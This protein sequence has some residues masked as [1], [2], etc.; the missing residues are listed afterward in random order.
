MGTCPALLTRANNNSWHTKNLR[1]YDEG[2]FVADSTQFF[3]EPY[4]T[5]E[6]Q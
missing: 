1:P 6:L 2:Y 4:N 3:E 5:E